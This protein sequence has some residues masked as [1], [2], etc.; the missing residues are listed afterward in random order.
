LQG[1]EEVE[2]WGLTCQFW[3][4]PNQKT[5]SEILGSS[6]KIDGYLCLIKSIM[7]GSSLSTSVNAVT[8]DIAVNFEFKVN[9]RYH[10]D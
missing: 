5:A 3:R 2:K 6:H 8:A 9:P 10:T 1:L 4:E 7:P